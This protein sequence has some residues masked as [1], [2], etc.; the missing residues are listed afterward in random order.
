MLTIP[1][2]PFTTTATPPGAPEGVDLRPASAYEAV[3]RQKVESLTED[4]K[5]IK[6]RLNTLFYT[7]I[8]AILIDLL[9]RWLVA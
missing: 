4:L 8:G 9:T 2:A 7:V 3:T 1:S 5:E 6:G